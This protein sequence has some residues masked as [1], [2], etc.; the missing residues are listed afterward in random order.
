MGRS[1]I[2]HCGMCAGERVNIVIKYLYESL[3]IN[4]L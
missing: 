4:L 3:V 1:L 2:H